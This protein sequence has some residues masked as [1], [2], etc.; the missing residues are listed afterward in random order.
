MQWESLFDEMIDAQKDKIKKCA[1][2]IVTRLTADDLLQP[3]DFPE[4]EGNPYFR[5]EEGVLEGLLTARMACLAL[6]Q[7]KRCKSSVLPD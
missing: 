4:L 1:D 3:N 2:K 7:E 6:L 5:Y